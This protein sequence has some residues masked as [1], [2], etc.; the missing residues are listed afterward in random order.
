MM[1]LMAVA[2]LAP[3]ETML[4]PKEGGTSLSGEPLGTLSNW[5]ISMVLVRGNTKEREEL[6]GY[7]KKGKSSEL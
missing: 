7:Q 1:G 4:H 2:S 3:L 5:G 6:G